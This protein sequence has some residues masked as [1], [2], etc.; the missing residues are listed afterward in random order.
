VRDR[1]DIHSSEEQD[2]AWR[3]LT[4]AVALEKPMCPGVKLLPAGFEK[5]HAA[6]E[7]LGKRLIVAIDDARISRI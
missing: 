5:I 3:A 2:M 6:I 4:E 1:N 7:A